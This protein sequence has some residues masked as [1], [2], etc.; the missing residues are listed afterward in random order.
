M[1]AVAIAAGWRGLLDAAVV[2]QHLFVGCTAE[3]GPAHAGEHFTA[4]GLIALDDASAS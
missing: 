1:D 3:W 2:A 4:C